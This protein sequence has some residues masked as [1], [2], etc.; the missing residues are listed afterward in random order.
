MA[1]TWARLL[2]EIV[3][4]SGRSANLSSFDIIQADAGAHYLPAGWRY[5]A[6]RLAGG[7]QLASAGRT[8]PISAAC[9]AYFR[10]LATVSTAISRQPGGC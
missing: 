6:L 1:W 2:A 9:S 3:Y 7:D 5:G 8:G 10:S 4:W